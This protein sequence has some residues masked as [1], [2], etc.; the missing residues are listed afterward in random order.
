[1][2]ASCRLRSDDRLG[3][4]ASANI[5]PAV[6]DIAVSTAEQNTYFNKQHMALTDEV[7][8]LAK[9]FSISLRGG[10]KDVVFR[11]WPIG[12]M[13]VTSAADLASKLQ[14]LINSKI[15]TDGDNTVRRL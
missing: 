8:R 9:T 4:A 10:G 7:A 15:S 2:G 5:A 12:D 13:N 1:M 14:S 6:N 3:L 11:N